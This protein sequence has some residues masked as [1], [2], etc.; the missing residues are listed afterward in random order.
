MTEKRLPYGE[1]IDWYSEQLA[2]AQEHIRLLLDQVIDRN[3]HYID[4]ECG[5]QDKI[6]K[7]SPE[8]II[9]DAKNWMS[10]MG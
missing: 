8:Q 5:W 6:E 7:N 4:Y 10:G 2:V 9:T 3:G 1:N